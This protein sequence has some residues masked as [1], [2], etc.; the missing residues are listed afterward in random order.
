MEDNLDLGESIQE[1][2]L[3]TEGE[4]RTINYNELSPYELE[5]MNKYD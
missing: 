2:I 3:I 4:G 5:E 1:W